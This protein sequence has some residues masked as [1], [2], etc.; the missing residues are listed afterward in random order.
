MA[1][2]VIFTQTNSN[3]TVTESG[4]AGTYT[5]ILS[6]QPTNDVIITL[7]N[8]NKQV[9]SDVTTLTFTSSNWD[10]PQTIT[11]TAVNDT[12]GE[13]N[14]T[15]VIQH[16]VSS[17]DRTYDAITVSNV[18]VAI[19]DND[20]PPIDPSFLPAVEQP[21]GLGDSGELIHPTFVDI[22][23][24]GDLDAIVGNGS[25][26]VLL[27]SNIGSATQPAFSGSTPLSIGTT[28]EG[29]NAPAFAD[30]DGDGDLDAFVGK[31]NGDKDF[32]RNSGTA[33]NPVFDSVQHN[34]F[35]FG[36][37]FG[38]ILTPTFV[39]IDNDGD[40]DAFIG[41]PKGET[42]YYRNDGRPQEPT[43]ATPEVNPFG[44]P[45]NLA[46]NST[47]TFADIDG[48]G[49]S[50]AIIGYNDGSV[51]FF[52]N[53][54]T[55]TA[56]AF[57]ELSNL[58]YMDTNGYVSPTL[59]DINADGD[60]DMFV[61]NK[62]G[63]MAFL[64]NTASIKNS[65]TITQSD[66]NTN[67]TEGGV[68]DTYTVVLSAQPTADVT[69]TLDNTNKQV[70]SDVTT[71]TFT[72]AD[73]NTPQT[74]TV[75]A[76]ND[77]VGEGKHT[78]VLQHTV[79]SADPSYNTI[80][81]SNVIVAVTDN[82]LPTNDPLFQLMPDDTFAFSTIADKGGNNIHT[83]FADIDSDGD[84]DVF[85][86]NGSGDMQF[87]ENIGSATQP[88][89]ANSIKQPF[90]LNNSEPEGAPTFADIDGDGDLDAIVGTASGLLDL[91]WNIGNA[92]KPN[93]SADSSNMLS[94]LRVE[95]MAA[96]TFVDIDGDGDLDAFV[97]DVNGD[98]N[99]YRN[100]GSATNSVFAE[101][102]IVNPFGLTRVG[103][104]SSPTF[105]DIDGDGDG[106]LDA[107]LGDGHGLTHFFRNTG[108]AKNVVFVASI[109]DLK[110]LSEVDF[111]AL[112]APIF[113]D[114][115][116]D[117][118]LEAFVADKF[119]TTHFFKNAAS[120]GVTVTQSN[121]NTT[122]SEGGVADTYSVVLN[123]APTQDVTITIDN[124]NQQ[125]SSDV[126]TLTFTSANWNTPQTV[127]VTAVNDTVGEGNHTGVLQH[128]VSSKDFNYNAITVN[129]VIV[130]ITDN[131]LPTQ[132]PY[133]PVTSNDD[134]FG[135]TLDGNDFTHPTFADIDSDG[136]LDALI[137]AGDGSFLYVENTGTATDPQFSKPTANPFGLQNVA[138]NATPTLVDID[139][140]GDLDVF[141][142]DGNGN[143][144]F[145]KNVGSA[146]HPSFDVPI[147]AP[148]GLDNF[149]GYTNTTLTFGD[150][151][152]DGNMDALVGNNRGEIRYYR[153]IGS[154]DN[155]SFTDMGNKSLD[156]SSIGEYSSPTLVDID[157]DGDL[158]ILVGNKN[159]DT[160]LF[161]NVGN[162][163]APEFSADKNTFGLHQNASFS[164][165][166]FVDI[167]A[168]GDLDFFTGS[169][170]GGL[171]FAR[172]VTPALESI[173]RN[174]AEAVT[175]AKTVSYTVTFNE[176]IITLSLDDFELVLTGSVSGT[177]SNL[178]ANDARTWTITVSD[179]TGDGGL[180][181]NLKANNQVIGAVDKAALPA[182]ST[183]EIYT[184]DM[185]APSTTY[186]AI[187][188]SHD[189][190]TSSTDFITQTAAQTL[191]ATLSSAL[192]ADEKAY[193]SLDNGATWTDISAMVSD[194]A[195]SW[196]NVH[197]MSGSNT[198]KLKVTDTAGNDSTLASQAYTVDMT[199]PTFDNANVNP[200]DNATTVSLGQIL[201]LPFSEA[202]SAN[203]DLSKVYLK[204]VAN[205]ATVPASIT[206]NS[207]GQLVI[208]PTS[209]L[210]FSTEYTV[211]WDAEALQDAAGNTVLA[212][213]DKTTYH[214]ITESVPVPTPT[215]APEPT[216]APVP[217]P[218]PAPVPE[219]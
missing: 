44:L 140:D 193:G 4:N 94:S 3:T 96:P 152:N 195:L 89:F 153:N 28:G 134:T 104:I 194:T 49:D 13:G 5:L 123:S 17:K 112:A 156:S 68:T 60:L 166:T 46:G 34:P 74:V 27:F 76:V 202:L 189:T 26:D 208:T 161:R 47:P 214:F 61:G 106:D 154:P 90:G 113:A 79:S 145:Y 205:N 203:S 120:A 178:E 149:D 107:L 122:V 22:D 180:Q 129:N 42:Y 196:T 88:T 102:T 182:F 184:L 199:A 119:G 116:G 213:S 20:L 97:G 39:D 36:R 63:R 173:V 114:I 136:D 1:A 78:G 29:G 144:S 169:E 215:P 148:F 132:A 51:H 176:D 198:L 160:L 125:V 218:T 139:A 181:L 53:T 71:L 9:N 151:D 131:D 40:P 92:T 25:G 117:G 192:A 171:S 121:G 150:I 24:D 64:E 165:P 41:A 80:T 65:V 45:T 109:D 162:A 55:T 200:A 82:D 190:G 174:S 118:N 133:F 14:H 95:Q 67:V 172:N 72:P 170:K 209:N 18:I 8:T 155:P 127:T 137:G 191:S 85:V 77:T 69:I 158:D 91:Y 177:L 128:T 216:P 66:S 87:F 7:D 163:T 93:F 30:I 37:D 35:G 10:T 185:T 100:T 81:V 6:T 12:I 84:L 48:D 201:T 103:S 168:D 2:S 19:T 111:K 33:T 157:S 188:I 108:D 54:G 99:F 62:Y 43:F 159:G 179:I 142:G 204:T 50:D 21:F 210:D 75:T 115:D 147:A 73:W 98:T 186:S 143:V 86:G 219:P 167:D 130:A 141:S 11:V 138:K 207:I 164:T 57:T 105:A 52:R 211:N 124:T 206:L 135:I 175:N 187:A 59:V 197:L 146:S 83:T 56:P 16:T 110:G 183:G 31:A 70:N 126:T 32:F 101:K 15:G 217:E 58:S 38:N 23:S 212:L